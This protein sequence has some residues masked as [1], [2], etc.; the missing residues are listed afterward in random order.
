MKRKLLN[1]SLVFAG[2]VFTMSVNAQNVTSGADSGPGSLRAAIGTATAG[3]T[4]TILPIVASVTLDSALTINKT[5]IITGTGAG[6][7][8]VS[9]ITAQ[10]VGRAF[11]ITNGN[12]T[13][14]NVN[15]SNGTAAD[16]G[17]FQVTNANLILNSLTVSNSKATGIA[18][19]GGAVLVSIGATLTANTVTFNANSAN[20]AGGAI[21][22]T[23]VFSNALK[24]TDCIFTD[25]KAGVTPA[26]PAP[27]NGGA[28]H[29]TGSA[30]ASITG[31]SA[32][33]NL[34]A[35]EGGAFWN[36]TGTMIV[37]DFTFTGNKASGAAANEGGGAIFNAGGILIVKNST[38]TNNA[39]D[40][41]AS[42][43]GGILNDMGTLTVDT[44]EFTG[45]TA[46]RAGG[47]IEENASLTS[48]L[49]LNGVTIDNNTASANPGNGGG[50]HITGAGFST[51]K[52]GNF[53]N[54]TASREGGAIWNDAGIM[55]IDSVEIDGNT[56]EGSAAANGGGGVFNVSGT[57]TIKNGTAI[58]NNLATG[59]SGSGGGIMSKAGSVI[60]DSVLIDANSANRAGGG[61]EI[62][63][64]TMTIHNS[65]LTN[66][67]VNG[68]AGL[69]APGSGG[70]IHVTG[71]TTVVSIDSS[72]ISDNLAKLQ[73]GALWNQ[74]GSTMSLNGVWV[75]NNTS[76]RSGG[77][78]YNTGGTVRVS[79][80]TLSN[81]TATAVTT[82]NGGGIASITGDLIVDHSTFSG[83]VAGNNGGGIYSNDSLNVNA[84]TFFQNEATENGGGIFSGVNGYITNTLVSGNLAI[85]G[86]EVSGSVLSLGFNLIENDDEMIFTALVS[87][88]LDV[89][90][91]LGALL[92]NNAELTPTHALLLSSVGVNAGDPADASADQRGYAVFGP[93]RDIGAF[94]LSNV[95]VSEIAESNVFAVYPNPATDLV[96]VSLENGM[97]GTAIITDLNGKVVLS[98]L[99]NGVASVNVSAL[100]TGMYLVTVSTATGTQTRKL[101]IK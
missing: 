34:A 26:T 1:L 51:I 95:S 63:D 65:T 7:A 77:G 67:D 85:V 58:T 22:V 60:I 61:I 36:G 91:S 79:R 87:D 20:R 21:E 100:K 66:N 6:G 16:G 98:S 49:I 64:G 72:L 47:A 11:N 50:L 45:N 43:G 18:G 41:T 69:P 17:A 83:N 59:A 40:G 25:N 38:L 28:V 56:A 78:I 10:N 19:S 68:T 80:S 101:Q 62:I 76:G 35:A 84:C 30:S 54:N 99:V 23:S 31:G 75:D 86:Q 29:I 15:V 93:R 44:T 48:Q 92:L 74:T 52:G 14:T 94:E 46:T 13:L 27:G 24:L 97:T 57:V 33:G 70:A 37:N 53:T 96:T 39:A 9:T 55:V 12:L 32:T 89:T 88:L 42:S 81:N 90:P 82:G 2:V 71:I 4:I 5:L 3:S 73:G 8:N